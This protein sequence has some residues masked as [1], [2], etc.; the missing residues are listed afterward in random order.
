MEN[1]IL[2]Q[3]EDIYL[4][5]FNENQ[6]L[7]AYLDTDLSILDVNRIVL[8]YTGLQ[9][10]E[11]LNMPYW[12]LPIWQHSEFM[13]NK[14][15]FSIEYAFSGERVH[16]E[17][18]HYD[19]EGTLHYVDFVLSPLYND[20]HEV[21]G[22]LA[23]TYDITDLKE[24]RQTLSQTR[25]ELDTFFDYSN[26][27]YLFNFTEHPIYWNK[28]NESEDAIR[29][30][31]ASQRIERFNRTAQQIFE[32][33]ADTFGSTPLSDLLNLPEST[34]LS[35]WSTLL[36]K[37]I[38]SIEHE[39]L[40]KESGTKVHLLTTL[41]AFIDDV[42]R[43]A[44][45]FAIHRNIT[46]RKNL[47]N[48]LR[49]M[50]TTDFLTGAKNR[51]SYLSSAELSFLRSKKTSTPLFVVMMDID[52]FKHINDTYGHDIG[53]VVLKKLTE[54]ATEKLGEDKLFGRMGGEEFSA[55]YTAPS[56]EEAF[57]IADRL[58]SSLGKIIIDSPLGEFTFTLSMGLTQTSP[59]TAGFDT[60]LKQADIA[61]YHAKHTGKNRV[62]IYN[63]TLSMT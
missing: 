61:L 32:I 45:N 21:A 6:Q 26:D 30:I 27:G 29:S 62:V 57:S 41:I 50:A 44:G 51:R 20:D 16:F 47:E 55:T 46:D 18:T 1:D 43:F 17:A 53:D 52:N 4:D 13:Q 40:R 9:K 56:L 11:I 25:R 3:H 48:K 5:I 63:N 37:G 14:L 31:M 8:D 28:Q 2:K 19:A 59:D 10:E 38:C 24:I 34:L 60:L 15:I 33:D 36:N 12:D 49:I 35:L 7:T 39:V 54:V 23:Q 58:R 22:F 42:G